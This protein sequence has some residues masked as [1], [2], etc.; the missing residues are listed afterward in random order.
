[1][2]DSYTP[3]ESPI[4]GERQVFSRPS[5]QDTPS[6]YVH[7][8]YSNG[9]LPPLPEFPAYSEVQSG[10]SNPLYGEESAADQADEPE[11]ADM[12]S[13]HG[14]GQSYAAP[15]SV[16]HIPEQYGDEQPSVYSQPLATDYSA[17][18][19]SQGGIGHPD[20][21]AAYISHSGNAYSHQD[22]SEDQTTGMDHGT[23]AAYS[24]PTP[25]M[26]AVPS[27]SSE[28]FSGHANQ[29]SKSDSLS[30]QGVI[31]EQPHSWSRS[32]RSSAEQAGRASHSARSTRE[33]LSPSPVTPGG[34]DSVHSFEPPSQPISTPAY[35]LASRSQAGAASQ[36]GRPQSTSSVQPVSRPTTSRQ[37]PSHPVQHMQPA[38]AYATY[39]EEED[40]Q[41]PAAA[42]GHPGSRGGGY[43]QQ[44][45]DY[46]QQYAVQASRPGSAQTRRRGHSRGPPS[47]PYSPTPG[48]LCICCSSQ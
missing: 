20:Q 33:V 34:T 35:P 44:E 37:S 26:L 16:E 45:E 14:Y 48:A 2:H 7:T 41:E 28:S 12:M 5:E 15:L 29:L 22:H 27:H 39:Q 13:S 40:Y 42:G 11:H 4:P 32:A 6:G 21:H 23:I 30:Q 24:Q 3:M 36:S 46:R 19:D 18:A 43:H 8:S 10:M 47:R 1:M 38:S 17:G 9:V 25:S 31:A